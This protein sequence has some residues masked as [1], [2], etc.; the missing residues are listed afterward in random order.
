MR[1]CGNKQ[2]GT[3]IPANDIWVAA[4]AM[5]FGAELITFDKHFQVIDGLVCSILA[6]NNEKRV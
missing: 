3:P 1:T 5:E 2:K 6:F 4:Q